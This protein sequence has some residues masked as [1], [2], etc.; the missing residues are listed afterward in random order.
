M[1]YKFLNIC[2][3]TCL[4]IQW[5]ACYETE[6]GCIDSLSTNYSIGADNPCDSCCVYPTFTLRLSHSFDT[7]SFN[8]NTFYTDDFG[9]SFQVEELNYFISNIRLITAEG[10]ASFP[11]DSIEISTL[12]GSDL[13]T[14]KA[15]ENFGLVNALSPSFNLGEFKEPGE[16]IQIGFGLGL[17]ECF[18]HI[19]T[20]SLEETYILR[21][22]KDSLYLNQLD[23]FI[24][25]Q[26]KIIRDIT[27]LES[28]L[29]EIS[30]DNQYQDL[31]IPADIQISKGVNVSVRLK[32]DVKTLFSGINVKHDSDTEII[33]RIN[34]NFQFAFSQN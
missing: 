9:N 8:T 18:N 32:L 2:F 19:D 17:D 7:L 25:Q 22:D 23:G 14:I 31:L 15:N 26:I 29:I 3:F 21:A 27:T 4:L 34:Q 10:K 6:E 24:F 12:K 33:D 28:L 13:K 20:P 5:F 30:G 1:G 11:L 16:Y